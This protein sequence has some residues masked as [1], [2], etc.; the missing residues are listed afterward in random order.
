[1]KATRETGP[2][3]HPKPKGEVARPAGPHDDM[4][5]ISRI[6]ARGSLRWQVT[7]ARQ[8]LRF[9][10]AFSAAKHGG[11]QRALELARQWRDS[12]L[13][14]LAP[15]T[16][17]QFSTL[18]RKSNKSGVP[19]VRRMVNTGGRINW[20]ATVVAKGQPQ[21][22]R[23]F[24]VALYGEEGARQRAIEARMSMLQE[25][26]DTF[27][28]F[29]PI[30][31]ERAEN[32][33]GNA[34]SL[35]DGALTHTWDS[36]PAARQLRALRDEAL[37]PPPRAPARPS[38]KRKHYKGCHPVWEVLLKWSGRQ[39]K[40]RRFSIRLYG[41]EGARRLAEAALEELLQQRQA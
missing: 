10:K 38:I 13:D 26:A 9:S 37:V 16:R 41:D 21:R 1:M 39:Y 24:S 30:A 23:M 31:R 25:Q 22:T 20:V 4:Y 27:H 32:T 14:R 7:I 29:S 33:H 28:V 34:K 19:G 12:V 35:S 17:R 5:C 15:A 3:V 2:P 40:V 8:G 18:L 11:A 36:E 6:E